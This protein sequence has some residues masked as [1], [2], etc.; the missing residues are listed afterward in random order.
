MSGDGPGVSP[1]DT[2]ASSGTRFVIEV[3]AWIA[4][5][6]AAGRL[7]G[8]GWYAIP[9]VLVLVALPALFNTPGDKNT[10]GIAT[11]GPIRIALEMLL[12]A[13]AVGSAWIVWPTWAAL[14]VTAVGLALLIT[15]LPRYRWLA[16][17]APSVGP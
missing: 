10:T 3:V 16:A 9:T 4:G 8:S 17:G 12:L 15:G 5:P 7:L 2:A 13:V 11:P 14:G 1:Y 6:W